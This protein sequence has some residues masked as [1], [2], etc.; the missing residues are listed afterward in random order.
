MKRMPLL[1]GVR[2]TLVPLKQKKN[3]MAKDLGVTEK[4]RIAVS[5]FN[6]LTAADFNEESSN[7]SR[8]F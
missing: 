3:G 5:C 7:T 6:P 2:K 8:P 1:A 4:L